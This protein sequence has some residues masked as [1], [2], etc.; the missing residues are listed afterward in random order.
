MSSF[1]LALLNLFALNITF[2]YPLKR[3]ERKTRFTDFFRGLKKWN[4][5]EKWVTEC[6]VTPTNR[7]IL[8][9]P[10]ITCSKSTMEKQEKGVKCVQS[11]QSKHLKYV[12]DVALVFLLLT[13]NIFHTFFYCVYCW[14]WWRQHQALNN[15]A[16]IITVAVIIIRHCWSFCS[17]I[18]SFTILSWLK[19]KF[20]AK[21]WEL[22]GRNWSSI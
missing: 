16:P 9:Q 14:L 3:L 11:W 21:A 1:F 2:L 13:L 17:F 10:T 12:S 15:Q 20:S 22:S 7:Y 5:R 19:S 4:I 18:T 6:Q 8:T